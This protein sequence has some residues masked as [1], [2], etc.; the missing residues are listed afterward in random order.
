MAII[1]RFLLGSKNY[2]AKKGKIIIEIDPRQTK[3]IKNMAKNIY[4][5]KKVLLKQDLSQ[6]DRMMILR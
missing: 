2:L 3:I 6:L 4:P 5:D 1:K